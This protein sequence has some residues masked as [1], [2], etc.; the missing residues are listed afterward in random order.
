M[1]RWEGTRQAT[2]STSLS[3]TPI[4][5]SLPSMKLSVRGSVYTPL[6]FITHRSTKVREPTGRFS[7]CAAL[8]MP[9]AN[10]R[11]LAIPCCPGSARIAVGT[12]TRCCRLGGGLSGEAWKLPVGQEGLEGEA[13]RPKAIDLVC[14]MGWKLP[15]EAERVLKRAASVWLRRI[16]VPVRGADLSPHDGLRC[17]ADTAVPFGDIISDRV[18]LRDHGWSTARFPADGLPTASET[19]PVDI[20]RIPTLFGDLSVLAGLRVRLRDLAGLRVRF[21]LASSIDTL[22]CTFALSGEEARRP[23]PKP[24]RAPVGEVR[25]PFGERTGGERRGTVGE[26][27][28]RV[29]PGIFSG[30]RQRGGTGSRRFFSI[31]DVTNCAA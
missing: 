25:R 16:A 21:A 7:L 17:V 15:V 1:L 29:L 5:Q 13:R 23:R 27:A 20:E 10:P 4:T 19:S 22:L 24:L 12:A 14:V 9:S 8:R 30:D 3:I 2:T 18:G 28:D 31:D 6:H 11:P 26:E